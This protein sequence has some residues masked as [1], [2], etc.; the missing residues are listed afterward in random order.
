MTHTRSKTE[1]VFDYDFSIIQTESWKLCAQE[2]FGLS[3]EERLSLDQTEG[4]ARGSIIQGNGQPGPVFCATLLLGCPRRENRQE[5]PD[6]P[7]SSMYTV[8]CSVYTMGGGKTTM[9]RSNTQAKHKHYILDEAKIKRA[10]KLLGTTTETETIE[11]ALEELIT[12]RERSTRAWQAHERFL[13]TGRKE[14]IVIRDVY[15]VLED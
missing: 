5:T 15:G 2:V 10:Q 9:A 14:Q 11:R 13:K 6:V 1:I 3:L 7:H 12:E 8:L 4:N